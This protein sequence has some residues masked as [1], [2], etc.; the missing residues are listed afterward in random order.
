[1]SFNSIAWG[2]SDDCSPMWN[3]LIKP[4]FEAFEA[5]QFPTAYVFLNKA[6]EKGCRDGLVLVKLGTINEING[7]FADAAKIFTEAE[8]AL[9]KS[10]PN[11]ELAKAIDTYL[12]RVYYQL[13]QYDKA[14]P[15]LEKALV[16]D[17]NN[18]M[19]LFMTGQTQRL[20]G[21]LDAAYANYRKALGVPLPQEVQP[22]P[23][24]A[25][26]KE[27]MIVTY[28]M[29]RTDESEK[30]ADTILKADPTNVTAKSYK[31]RI[32]QQRFQKQQDQTLDEI[33]KQYR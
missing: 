26:L 2:S 8:P 5:N 20:A 24:L 27:L 15:Y 21:K 11:H 30:Y 19:L 23:K 16:L 13:D 22:D 17:P 3:D 7:H 25:L 9:K 32:T 1:M 29:K 4:G 14:L 6:Y 12:G 18:F 33:I 28:D 31:Q 10:Y